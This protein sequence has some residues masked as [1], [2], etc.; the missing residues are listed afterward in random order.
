MKKI[1]IITMMTCAVLNATAQHGIKNNITVQAAA[2]NANKSLSNL[3]SATAINS[4]LLP[5]TD[6]A[7]SLGNSS[8]NWRNLFMKGG[9]YIN[10]ALT[11]HATGMKNIFVGR[12]AGNLILSGSYNTGVG[13]D[14]L[15]NITKG[16]YNSAL[17]FAALA[18]NTA[19]NLNT[20]TGSASLLSNTNGSSNTANGAYALYSNTK[21]NNILLLVLTRFLATQ[22]VMITLLLVWKP[23]MRIQPG[24]PMWL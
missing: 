10:Q 12:Y 5:G 1:I 20:A 3:A 6:S 24:I 11:L 2:D 4:S 7:I 13:N 22:R 14:A 15:T 16:V 9:I 18:G 21:G 23:Y 8:M 19:G 17:G